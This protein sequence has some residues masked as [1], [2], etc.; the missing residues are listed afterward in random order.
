M[1]L[2]HRAKRFS[3]T[4]G[5][6][7]ALLAFTIVLPLWRVILADE[8]AED[9]LEYWLDRGEEAPS[10][11]EP[12]DSADKAGAHTGDSQPKPQGIPGVVELSD[13]RTSAGM[14]A[15]PGDQP[16]EVFVEAEKRWRRVPPV[17]ALSITA[18]V[19]SQGMEQQWRPKE[20]GSR[21]RIYTGRQY[22]VRRLRWRI[23]LADGTSIIG[24]IKGQ[25]IRLTPISQ[26]TPEDDGPAGEAP[27]PPQPVRF[28]LPERTKGPVGTTL[29]EIV[30]VKRIILSRRAMNS[31]AGDTLADPSP[32][33]T[34]TD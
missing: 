6:L 8:P 1:T 9:D 30:Y 24:V 22:P 12:A 29:D 7:A 17:C 5:V 23:L 16:L 21:E 18:E 19:V 26:P 28:V 11:D 14:L 27:D 10:G 4:V 20:I 2:S 34:P 32:I 3:L 25:S 13:G 31:V 15:T 33:Q